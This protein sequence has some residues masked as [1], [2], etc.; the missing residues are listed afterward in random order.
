MEPPRPTIDGR[1][2]L[3]AA[4]IQSTRMHKRRPNAQWPMYSPAIGDKRRSL[5]AKETTATQQ[6][7]TGNMD[8]RGSR[9]PHCC[10]LS[11][12]TARA[13]GTLVSP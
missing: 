3:L 12:P 10:R 11:K 7:H 4:A 6:K 13:S 5:V 2:G 9:Q 8:K 1:T